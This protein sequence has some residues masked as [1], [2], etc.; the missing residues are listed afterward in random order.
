MEFTF[1]YGGAA[2]QDVRLIATNALLTIN[3][4]IAVSLIITQLL[5]EITILVGGII[6]FQELAALPLLEAI[7][8]RV[9]VQHPQIAVAALAQGLTP[10]TFVPGLV[11][12][13]K[14]HATLLLIAKDYLL[15][16]KIL[17]LENG[18]QV[19][20]ISAKKIPLPAK[21]PLISGRIFQ[22]GVLIPIV[23]IPLLGAFL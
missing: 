21:I 14:L 12:A 2:K 1:A 11:A 23:L 22:K 16:A 17:Q 4:E 18:A 9:L 7:A 20:A 19:L 5:V 15:P 3:Q 13:L 10:R 6:V 8:P